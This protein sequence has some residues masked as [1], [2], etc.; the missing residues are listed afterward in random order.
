[1]IRNKLGQCIM[2]NKCA[3]E[4]GPNECRTGCKCCEWGQLY[5]SGQSVEFII[6]LNDFLNEGSVVL[7]TY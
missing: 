5:E 4:A 7:I 2:L 3:A 1:M 6:A